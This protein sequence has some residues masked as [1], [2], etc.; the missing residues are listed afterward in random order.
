[1]SRVIRSIEG[2]GRR[3]LSV[4]IRR[5]S[6]RRGACSWPPRRILLLRH[7]RIG[8]WVITTPLV[9]ELRQAFPSAEIDVLA[10]AGNAPLIAAD[11]RITRVH[12]LPDRLWDRR[13]LVRDCRN[14]QYD[15]AFQLVL[16][17]TT[18]PAILLRRCAPHA[19]LVGNAHSPVRIVFDRPV[20]TSGQHFALRTL[21]LAAGLLPDWQPVDSTHYSLRIPKRVREAS[22]RSI[23]EHGLAPDRF[24]LIN[25]SAGSP[26]RT[27]TP[28][29]CLALIDILR[30]MGL[31]IA[32][33]GGPDDHEAIGLLCARSGATA[34]VV[35]GL[36]ESMALY[37]YPLLVIT[38]DTS[39]VHVAS[40]ASR[41]VV[42]LYPRD[43]D[44]H[45]WGPMGTP[46]RTI[47]SSSRTIAQGIDP[48]VVA[49]AV[50]DLLK[51]TRAS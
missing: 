31:A 50:V 36:V 7:D 34:L 30:P 40:A 42:A 12:I 44:Y 8:D 51:T 32:V 46:Y 49:K 2:L 48:E 5:L 26:D 23:H 13:A 18:T 47:L 28:G 10:S 9:S 39:I 11:D 1:M 25:L 20:N 17:A 22:L 41:P 24:I 6:R 29:L 4:P 16:G 37:D 33:T 35:K 15:A 27:L 19:L 21:S 14:R 38:P 43:A 45:G 3:L